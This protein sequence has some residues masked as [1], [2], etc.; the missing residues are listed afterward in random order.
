MYFY[1]A[2]AAWKANDYKY[3]CLDAALSVARW[4]KD[5]SPAMA[6]AWEG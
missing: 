5:P 6:I 2:S 3:V 1:M 4:R